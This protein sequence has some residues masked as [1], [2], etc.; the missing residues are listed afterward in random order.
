MI[1]KLPCLAGVALLCLLPGAQAFGVASETVAVIGRWCDRMLPAWITRPSL[2]SAVTE[3]MLW[4]QVSRD[5][6][7]SQLTAHSLQSKLMRSPTGRLPWTDRAVVCSMQG[8]SHGEGRTN[9][10]RV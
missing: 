2:E 5:S 4:F 9:E 7:R 8:E 6:N 1:T 3:H 10:C